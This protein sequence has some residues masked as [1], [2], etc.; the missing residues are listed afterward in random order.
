VSP[1]ASPRFR[2]PSGR[3]LAALALAAVAILAVL[4]AFAACRSSRQRAA[5]DPTEQPLGKV[6]PPVA[7]EMLRD[8]P[9]LAI[10]DLRSA[11]EF[12][13]PLGHVNGARNLPLADLRE[14]YRDLIDLKVRTFLVYCSRDEC[15]GE[16]ME[17]LFE[18]GFTN[19]VLI[20][21]G[22]EAWLAGGYGTVGFSGDG[23]GLPGGRHRLSSST[24]HR[25]EAEPPP[26]PR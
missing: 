15:R 6:T 12:N 25:A 22:I 23:A 19:A 7:F 10:V 26:P 4:L 20:D 13:G 16:A 9:Y 18:H 11:E 8:A 17:F 21:G 1:A 24:H 3:R 2:A 5:V 14:K